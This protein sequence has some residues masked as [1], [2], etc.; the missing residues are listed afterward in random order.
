MNVVDLTAEVTARAIV[1]RERIAEA[2]GDPSAVRLLAVTKGFGPEAPSAALAAGLGHIGE[3]YAQELASKWPDVVTPA[4]VE[5]DVHFIGRLQRNKVRTVAS[6]VDTWQS[7]DRA[8]LGAEIAKRAPGARVLV[9]INVSGEAQQGGCPLTGVDRLA[10]ELTDL[11]LDV[12]GLMA[13][14]GQSAPAEIRAQFD[15]VRRAADRLSL[16]ER[17]LGMSDDLDIAVAAGSTM[18]RIGTALFGPRPRR[19]GGPG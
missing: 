7:V 3:S 9:Q 19:D 14:A 1:V 16:P 17:S 2:G 13:I 4:D 15:E 6:I 8:S 5:P 18:V 10:A 11:G 12:A